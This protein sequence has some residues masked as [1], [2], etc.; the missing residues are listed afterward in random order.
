MH[1]L[2]KLLAERKTLET[3]LPAQGVVTL[4]DQAENS[5]L[6]CHTL[7]AIPVKRGNGVE[8]IEDIVPVFDIDVKIKT[9]TEIKKVYLAPSMEEIPFTQKEGYVSFTVPKI[10]CAQI[11]VLNY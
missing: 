3:S 2:D 5:R 4:M 6:V 10:E 8:I 11:T 1:T 9:E 7:Y